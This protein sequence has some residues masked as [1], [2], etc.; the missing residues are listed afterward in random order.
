M[1]SV[2]TWYFLLFFH[3][4]RLFLGVL[5]AQAG[6]RRG[7]NCAP[8]GAPRLWAKSMAV[9]WG[10]RGFIVFPYI[11]VRVLIYPLLLGGHSVWVRYSPASDMV[12]PS[13]SEKKHI[14][15]VQGVFPSRSAAEQWVSR[16]RSV[17]AKHPFNHFQ[18]RKHTQSKQLSLF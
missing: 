11:H 15:T 17:V 1:C 8:R 10:V 14:F 7:I 12:P 13:I 18:E 4:I 16:I 5:F 3:Y 6:M 9:L 2:K